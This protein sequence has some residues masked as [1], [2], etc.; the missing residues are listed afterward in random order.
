M[1]RHTKFPST[2]RHGPNF[3]RAN[4]AQNLQ[5][6]WKIGKIKWGV[7]RRGGSRNSRFVL[8]PDV[9][10]ASEVSIFNQESLT[11]TDFLADGT[12]LANYCGKPP[13]WNPP[14][15]RWV[16]RLLGTPLPP[17][18]LRAGKRRLATITLVIKIEE[19]T[20][21]TTK[22]LWPNSSHTKTPWMLS[23]RGCMA[24]ETRCK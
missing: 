20:E 17:L 23:C 12:Q 13:S 6:I 14:H 15:S 11:I 3:I 1:A 7:S 10:I 18:S 16:Q 2:L 9:T 8:K 4:S 24:K 5:C 22:V 19:S 21:V